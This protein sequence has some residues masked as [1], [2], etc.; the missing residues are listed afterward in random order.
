MNHAYFT[1]FLT[2]DPELECDENGVSYLNFEIVCYS[3]RRAKST[4]EKTKIPTYLQFEAYHTGAETIA[5]LACQGSKINIHATARN[6]SKE[7]ACV[8][9]RVNEFDLN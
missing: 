7:D 8:V 3:Y 5:K 6:Y 1:G 2:H 9:F 4:G